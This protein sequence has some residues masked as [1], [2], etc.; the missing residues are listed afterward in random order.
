MKPFEPFAVA[1]ELTLPRMV[2]VLGSSADVDK[3]LVLS[4]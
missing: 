4:I 2:C 3:V 1:I